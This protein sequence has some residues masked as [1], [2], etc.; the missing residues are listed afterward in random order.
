MIADK[1]IGGAYVLKPFDLRGEHLIPPQHLAPNQ[2]LAI[3]IAHRRAL[4]EAGYIEVHPQRP[5]PWNP[6]DEGARAALR[7]WTRWQLDLKDIEQDNA[8][9][10]F[11]ALVNTLA[12]LSPE[13][14]HEAMR[15]VEDAVALNRNRH[16]DPTP[17]QRLFSARLRES[18]RGPDRSQQIWPEVAAAIVPPPR[19]GQQRL[20][21]DRAIKRQQRARAVK[22]LIKIQSLWAGA[23]GRWQDLND[24]AKEISAE[25][26][27]VTVADLKEA[28]K[29]GPKRGY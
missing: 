10:E 24:L 21:R 7:A 28:R 2:V 5:P 22:T 27:G 8:P 3:S 17:L 13:A 11:N 29:R 19:S 6:K 1:D 20:R 25:R 26:E 18:D 9:D 15:K 23:Y 16:D 4:I 14:R 12:R